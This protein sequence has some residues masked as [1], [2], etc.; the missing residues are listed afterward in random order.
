MCPWEKVSTG[1]YMPDTS[2]HEIIQ[3]GDDVLHPL[4]SVVLVPGLIA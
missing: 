1:A 2:D 4:E 3:G